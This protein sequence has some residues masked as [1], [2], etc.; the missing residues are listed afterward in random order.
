MVPG[1][2]PGVRALLQARDTPGRSRFTFDGVA[3]LGLLGVVAALWMP[4]H[5]SGGRSRNAFELLDA[6]EELGVGPSLIRTVGHWLLPLVPVLAAL[7]WMAM[8]LGRRGLVLATVGA[9][10]GIVGTGV[11][12]T[13]DATGSSGLGVGVAVVGLVGAATG[14]LGAFLTR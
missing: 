11:L 14:A 10:L 7:A 3:A 2:L 6:A 12:V 5:H 8:L 9:A 13:F 1:T 4:W